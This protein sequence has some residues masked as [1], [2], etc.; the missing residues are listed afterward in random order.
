MSVDRRTMLLMLAAA[1]VPAWAQQEGFAGLGSS[2]EGFARVQSGK[3][4]SFPADHGPHPAYRIEWWYVTANLTGEDGETYGA[5]F[6]LF[7]QAAAPPP[8]RDGWE[9]QQFWMGHAAI[10]SADEHLHAEKLAR[11]GVGQAGAHAQP[12]SVWIDD[13]RFASDGAAFS[14]LSLSVDTPSLGYDLRFVT[15]APMVKQGDAG[16]SVKSDRGQ[17]SYYVSQPFFS[18]EGALRFGERQVA[19]TGQ[20]WMDREWSSQPLAPDQEGWDWF[21]LH[22][23][24]GAKVMLFRL[25][26]TGGDHYFAGNWIE[27]DGVSKPIPAAAIAMTPLE[28]ARVAGRDVPVRWRLS[29]EGRDLSVETTPLN[30]QSWNGTGFPYWEGPITISGSESG[31]GYLEMTGYNPVP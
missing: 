30:P 3:A 22:L 25:R 8:Q 20:G 28:T 23:S 12:F 26:H 27:A 5:Q 24:S 29:I 2:G 13:W 19:V 31:V 4:L 10:T 6:T 1:P 16:Y 7:R 21:S 11:G 9:S 18:V 14:P 15:D 17:A